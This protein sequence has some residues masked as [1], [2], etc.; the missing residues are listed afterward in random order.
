MRPEG[1][2]NLTATTTGSP[3][4]KSGIR[5]GHISTAGSSN[6]SSTFVRTG[7]SSFSKRV[8]I[9]VCTSSRLPMYVNVPRPNRAASR[10]KCVFGAVPIP[11][12]KRRL[13]PRC[14]RM[15]AKSSASL[16]T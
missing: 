8:L 15:K 2:E 7:L 3:T 4:Y 9:F 13:R 11:T 10:M 1:F 16:P 6:L 5:C 12:V 14:A